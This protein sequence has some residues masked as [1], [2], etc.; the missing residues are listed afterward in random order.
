MVPDMWLRFKLSEGTFVIFRKSG[1]P[2]VFIFTAWM[3]D[4]I[5]SPQ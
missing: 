4:D 1:T 5:I 3:A 2:K